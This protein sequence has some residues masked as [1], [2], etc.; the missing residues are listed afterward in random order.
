M[1]R[2]KSSNKAVRLCL[3]LPEN[4]YTKLVDIL[5]SPFSPAPEGK[6][7]SGQLSAFFKDSVEQFIAGNSELTL[8]ERFIHEK[9]LLQ[10]YLTFKKVNTGL[11]R[12]EME[13]LL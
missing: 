1:A 2:P 10:E 3:T 8:M 13:E 5:R 6:L 7:E 9:G 12:K 11:L 4:Y